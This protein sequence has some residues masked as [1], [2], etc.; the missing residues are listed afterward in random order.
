MFKL[1]KESGEIT[2]QTYKHQDWHQVISR[3]H[4]L[5]LGETEEV[6]DDGGH[7]G[8]ALNLL[9]GHLE[10][11]QPSQLRLEH[12]ES[13][14]NAR[15]GEGEGGYLSSRPGTLILVSSWNLEISVVWSHEAGEPRYVIG[16]D[17][18][19]GAVR[20]LVGVNGSHVD[21]GE[22]HSL[23]RLPVNIARTS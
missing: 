22:N 15:E 19:P 17:Q 7:P 2:I 13:K 12:V 16:E 10:S 21:L 18:V 23:H 20:L 1:T 5:V 8:D 6:H 4:R 3:R 11:R 14:I 9:L